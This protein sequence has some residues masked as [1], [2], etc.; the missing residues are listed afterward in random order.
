MGVFIFVFVGAIG[1]TAFLGRKFFW[2]KLK[3]RIGVI[4]KIGA[5]SKEEAAN[6]KGSEKKGKKTKKKT[7][8]LSSKKYEMQEV[9]EEPNEKE[10]VQ[11]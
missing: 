3:A 8:K 5:G 1:I 4:G 7:R 11:V 10:E 9:K 2:H 6:V